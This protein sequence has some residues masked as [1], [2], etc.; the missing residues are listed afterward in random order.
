MKKQLALASV[1]SLLLWAATAL[2]CGGGFGDNL[3]LAPTQT[4]VLS[5]KNGVET[6]Y[7]S[8]TFCGD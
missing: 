4:I 2:P 7:F 6:Y 5:H 3:E 1:A 8:P